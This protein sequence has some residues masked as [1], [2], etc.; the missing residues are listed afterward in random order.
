MSSIFSGKTGLRHQFYKKT[1]AQL[2]SA[3][4]IANAALLATF[5]TEGR[6]VYMDNTLDADVAVLLVHPDADSTVDSN[7]LFWIE[8]PTNRVMNYDVATS[9]GLLID[10]GTKMFIYTLSAASSGA[11]RLALWG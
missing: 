11:F 10:P 1:S 8:V 6:L 5:K 9:P 2:S 4:S 7:R 3:N